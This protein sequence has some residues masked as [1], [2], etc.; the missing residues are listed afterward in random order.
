MVRLLSSTALFLEDK[1]EKLSRYLGFMAIAFL[2]IM[3]VF[4]VLDIILR[5]TISKPIQGD[6]EII[7][8]MMIGTGFLGLA[9]CA[10]LNMHIK[11]DLLVSHFNAR[12]RRIIDAFN[13]IIALCLCTVFTWRSYT[14]G[15]FIKDMNKTTELLEVPVYPFYWVIAFSYIVLCLVIITKLIRTIIGEERK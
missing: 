1:I 8:M 13:Y 14:E 2:F 12:S 6:I 7:E 5:A 11:V 10:T 3:M 15:F 9:W 4:T